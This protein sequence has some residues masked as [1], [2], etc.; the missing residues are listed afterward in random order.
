[1]YNTTLSTGSNAPRGVKGSVTLSAPLLP[2][3]LTFDNVFGVQVD[4]AFLENNGI[5]CA[6][7]K[8]YHGTGPGD[9]GVASPSSYHPDDIASK[10]S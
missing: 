4:T 7:L 1:M 5:P 6:N 3:D 8:G 2:Q 9:S 10:V